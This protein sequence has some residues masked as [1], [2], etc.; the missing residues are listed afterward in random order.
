MR[1]TQRLR[2]TAWEQIACIRLHSPLFKPTPWRFAGVYWQPL[3]F[4]H[5]LFLSPCSL[6]QPGSDILCISSFFLGK[7]MCIS[8]LYHPLWT[9]RWKFYSC[10]SSVSIACQWSILCLLDWT[11]CCLDSWGDSSLLLTVT[12]EWLFFTHS[13][14]FGVLSFLHIFNMEKF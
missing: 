12:F 8:V 9:Q 10:L 3:G 2:R 4:V 6:F 7:V 11:S 13:C 5:F 14:T 1:K